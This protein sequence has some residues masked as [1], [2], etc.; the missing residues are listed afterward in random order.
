MLS[1]LTFMEMFGDGRV[2]ALN[3]WNTIMVPAEEVLEQ[4][5]KGDLVHLQERER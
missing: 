2:T 4:V 1:F 3:P 5:T